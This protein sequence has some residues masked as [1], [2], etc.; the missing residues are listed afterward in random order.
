MVQIFVE[1]I[2]LM[3]LSGWESDMRSLLCLWFASL[4]ES[5]GWRCSTEK[6][7]WCRLKEVIESGKFRKFRHFGDYLRLLFRRYLN[8]MV[9][10][11]NFRVIPKFSHFGEYTHFWFLRF[12]LASFN[13]PDLNLVDILQINQILLADLKRFLRLSLSSF[14][15]F[16]FRL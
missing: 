13:F 5:W 9:F 7:H 10:Q 3:S 6:N 8:L 2:F 15:P 4:I 1:L 16:F 12:N 14:S 11:F